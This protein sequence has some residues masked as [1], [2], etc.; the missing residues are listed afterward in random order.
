MAPRRIP[1]PAWPRAS[2]AEPLTRPWAP[3]RRTAR[4]GN[5]KRS[6]GYHGRICWLSW[7]RWWFSDGSFIHEPKGSARTCSLS[8]SWWRWMMLSWHFWR[9]FTGGLVKLSEGCS[10]SCSSDGCNGCN[11]GWPARLVVRVMGKDGL[12]G[13]RLVP[14][15]PCLY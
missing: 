1:R 3:A 8:L 11:H 4:L 5:G 14:P 9:W 15:N 12:A 13:Q 7:W 10:K 6:A 2:A